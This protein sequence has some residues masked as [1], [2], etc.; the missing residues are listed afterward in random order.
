MSRKKSGMVL[1]Y[2]CRSRGGTRMEVK[3]KSIIK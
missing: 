2:E 1:G 3:L